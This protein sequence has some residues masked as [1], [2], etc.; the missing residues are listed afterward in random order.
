MTLLERVIQHLEAEASQEQMDIGRYAER[1]I[2]GMLNFE[3]LELISQMLETQ[4]VTE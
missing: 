3:L 1:R 2:E 4:E